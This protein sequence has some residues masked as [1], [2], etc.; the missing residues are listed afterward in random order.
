MKCAWIQ[1]NNSHRL[2]IF[3]GGFACDE[4]LLKNFTISQCDILMFY[5]YSD[6]NFEI[7]QEAF[8]YAEIFHAAW[9]FGVW[10][11]DFVLP[12]LP[13]A[14]MRIALCGSP[15]PVDDARGIPNAI[16]EG[17]RDNFCE[18]VKEKFLA[19]VF[20]ARNMDASRAL[21]ANRNV[22]EEKAELENLGR[23]FK[24]FE[25]NPANWTRAIATRGDK[26]FPHANLKNAWGGKLEIAEG[27]HFPAQIFADGLQCLFADTQSV[28]KSFGGA[29][30]SYNS[31]AD[32]QRKVAKRLA[33]IVAD[34][35][36]GASVE[37][38][39]EIGV[40]TGFLTKEI[41]K[42]LNAKQ[43]H[44]NDLS[45]SA[46]DYVGDILGGASNFIAGDILLQKLPKNLD[47]IV[48]ASC[49]Q[50]LENL[51]ALFKKLACNADGG[52]L[53]AFSTFLPNNL[54]ELRALSG[55]GLKYFD[56]LEIARMLELCGF[57]ILHS[58]SE[59]ITL[60]FDTPLAV[61]KHLK[62]SGVCGGFAEFWTPQKLKKFSREYSARFS[63]A[64]GKV[65]LTY[66]PVY[67]AAKRREII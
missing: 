59:V 21:F 38:L 15:Y 4:N 44:L 16:F 3:F 27:E 61:L 32:V 62:S 42:K 31:H 56:A 20:G 2:L 25:G 40:G 47:L 52:A 9:S 7:P 24:T 10:V 48:S 23:A 41:A 17:T 6:L 53:L 35:T 13:P 46:A 49:F 19:R 58:E 45:T 66:A 43:W 14:K 12:K 39:L 64:E 67:F 34:Y 5:D 63:N 36:A 29:F 55:K 33:E 65:T 1:K 8:A 51:E 37:N 22:A 26:I 28:A 11:A 18:S 60:E 57:E 30:E 50:W 54:C